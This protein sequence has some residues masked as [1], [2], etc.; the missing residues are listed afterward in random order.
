[1]LINHEITSSGPVGFA[2]EETGNSTRNWV[3]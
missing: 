3:P 1:M 2:V